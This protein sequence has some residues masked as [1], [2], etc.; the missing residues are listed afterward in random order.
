MTSVATWK[1]GGSG[2]RADLS[3]VPAEVKTLEA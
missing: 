3:V 2:D 1:I